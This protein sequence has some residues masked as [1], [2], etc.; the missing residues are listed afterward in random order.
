MER[1]HVSRTFSAGAVCVAYTA[2][3]VW[4]VCVD[5]CRH[6]PAGALS[7]ARGVI[8]RFWHVP[9]RPP[10]GVVNAGCPSSA[11]RKA[12][13][14][15]DARGVLLMAVSSADPPQAAS[16]AGA[17]SAA[18][19]VRASFHAGRHLSFPPPSRDRPRGRRRTADGDDGGSVAFDGTSRRK[20]RRLD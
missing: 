10:R 1:D 18:T 11:A 13:P 5:A 16:S 20:R 2:P 7:P 8:C 12:E 3:C 4:T 9:S 14:L 19:C 17:S 6:M 15:P